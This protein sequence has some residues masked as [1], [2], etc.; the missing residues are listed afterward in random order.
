M[1]AHGMPA[2][3]RD[4]T[5][6]SSAWERNTVVDALAEFHRLREA[7]GL[8]PDVATRLA[9]EA[10]AA[11]LGQD[12]ASGHYLREAVTLL[13]ALAS[14]DDPALSQIGVHGLFPSLVEPLGDAFTPQGC[15]IYNQLF[16]QVIQHC[17][18]QPDGA[19]LD[20]QLHRFGLV[21]EG[22]LLARAARIRRLARFNKARTHQIKKA[23]V[24]SRVTLGADIAVTSVALA[25]LKQV[26]PTAAIRLVA[27]AKT[28]QLFAGDRRV[29]LCALEYPRSGGLI[30]RLTSWQHTVEA[31]EQETLGLDPTEYVIVDPDS[32][33]T[34]LGLLPLVPDER[35]YLLF[36][37][38][39]YCAAGLEKLS[40]L[41]AHW[42]QQVFG[43]AEPV[44][45]YCAPSA[46]DVAA[47]KHIVEPLKLHRPGPMVSVNLG[48]GANPTKRLPDPFEFRLLAR[49]LSAGATIILDKGGDP[50][51]VARIEAL[52]AA[53]G[54]Q[55]FRALALDERRDA[56]S[57]LSEVNETP[58]LTW[59]GGIGRFA[60]LIG[61]STAYIGYDSA[62]QHM[63]AALGVP[64]IDIFTGFS[65]PRMPERWSPYGSGAVHVLVLDA[66]GCYPLARLD[67]IVEDVL[68][69][70]PRI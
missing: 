29:Q 56:M 47:A 42:L 41:T 25:G 39:S 53:L 68:A 13:C 44:Y 70:V 35:A 46:L 26:F 16:A 55:G 49:L 11:V 50:E 66:A 14:L 1:N 21:T 38:R 7:R 48:V 2:A 69:H 22:D 59:Q 24:L 64:T 52:V 19:A 40:A 51:E 61:E 8:T 32:R 45:P 28:Q 65:S 15:A 34:Q 63:A 43:M 57:L 9:T 31:I 30:E 5:G 67:A 58:L 18:R 33:L 20:R 4:P 17:R 60:A 27:S 12:K 37:S 3:D 54:G 23:F 62:G 10:A 36:E 6:R